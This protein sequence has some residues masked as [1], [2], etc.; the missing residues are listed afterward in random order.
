VFGSD[1][2]RDI[3][4]TLRNDPMADTI[5]KRAL[6]AQDDRRSVQ[7]YRSGPAHH[8]IEEEAI[9]Y[10]VEHIAAKNRGLWTRVKNAVRA[11]IAKM[12]KTMPAKVNLTEDEILDIVKSAAKAWA[13][14]KLPP[15]DSTRK[16][17]RKSNAADRSAQADTAKG[18]PA[19]GAPLSE[20]AQ[21]T[22]TAIH[23]AVNNQWQDRA[24]LRDNLFNQV[25][26]YTHSATSKVRS[27]LTHYINE[28]DA[29][30]SVAAVDQ[31]RNA[32]QYARQSLQEGY[33]ALSAGTK[34]FNGERGQIDPSKARAIGQAYVV[35][36]ERSVGNLVKKLEAVA[37]KHGMSYTAMAN[38]YT[39]LVNAKRAKAYQTDMVGHMDEF[40]R[41]SDN[42]K[43]AE[44]DH[45][46]AA[47]HNRAAQKKILANSDRLAA[48]HA[49][50]QSLA[51]ATGAIAARRRVSI[52]ADVAKLQHENTVLTSGLYDVSAHEKKYRPQIKDIKA[53]LKAATARVQ[54]TGSI[55]SKPFIQAAAEYSKEH[56]HITADEYILKIE[57]ELSAKYPELEDV[58]KLNREILRDQNRL[59]YDAHLIDKDAYERND[60]NEFYTPW[61]RD[62]V[63]EGGDVDG[64]SAKIKAPQKLAGLRDSYGLNKHGSMREIGDAVENTMLQHNRAVSRSLHN[65]AG[66][67]LAR[68]LVAIGDAEKLPQ[69]DI[70]QVPRA[71]RANMVAV[72]VDGKQELYR[73]NDINDVSAFM[74]PNRAHGAVLKWMSA[75]MKVPRML[76]TLDPSF[77]LAQPIQDMMSAGIISG[78]NTP[79]RMMADIMRTIPKGMA[80]A[81]RD[82]M[83]YAST[84]PS[85]VTLSRE[86]GITGRIDHDDGL[87]ESIFT[88]H[89]L[90][91]GGLFA[92]AKRNVV[93]AGRRLER[94]NSVADAT[95]RA[96]IYDDV[97]A[98]KVAEG[99]S[100]VEANLAAMDVANNVINFRKVGANPITSMLVSTIPFFNAQL[101]SLHV[102][103]KVLS[104]KNLASEDRAR[105]YGTLM[106]TAAKLTSI[107]VIYALATAGDDKLADKS[108]VE[109]MNNFF[110][111]LSNG[112]YI[113]VPVRSEFGF[114]WK[115]VPEKLI[116]MMLRDGKADATISETG[117]AIL[118]GFQA[119][120]LPQTVGGGGALLPGAIK[121]LI[122]LGMNKSFYS[123]SPIVPSSLSGLPPS[124][125]WDGA[126]GELATLIGWNAGISPKK[127]DHLLRSYGGGLT[128]WLNTMAY[129]TMTDE[130]A[131]KQLY[132]MPLIKRFM[133]SEE[134]SKA[135]QE[136]YDLIT[137]QQSYVKAAKKAALRGDITGA[138]YWNRKLDDMV[139]KADKLKA[140][141]YQQDA[142]TRA[143]RDTRDSDKYDSAEKRRLLDQLTEQRSALAQ[144]VLNAPE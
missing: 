134:G 51:G 66:V 12:F 75:F 41:L 65:V 89:G 16:F 95:Q 60:A 119:A 93:E 108:D 120:Y 52:A 30:W 114:M 4:T 113:R 143:I 126:T 43:A 39:Q 68:D 132:Q 138:D 58:R 97:Y 139:I 72:T 8:L 98:R 86:G 59:R 48:L 88:K 87:F 6:Y 106:R 99:Q 28:L 130:R 18:K 23:Q 128:V 141:K 55:Y 100:P 31:A 11:Y 142:I 26:D 25:F 94:M 85:I 29:A 104:G 105:A 92:G 69:T 61:L 36:S 57:R 112:Q 107:A 81:L 56:G 5:Y 42:L 15:T 53:E 37:A 35:S 40:D 123:D 22:R 136:L 7:D 80:E 118:K 117:K 49:Q 79:F 54:D 137:E 32:D 70:S 115:F 34:G 111:P 71:E 20:H 14:D 47:T 90:Q 116:H 131:D 17:S 96:R 121:P 63:D 125:Q 109:R 78:T 101:Q 127:L 84:D 110:I 27:K 73:I 1:L 102:V 103:M 77:I 122:E 133:A 82:P 2:V 21:F 83:T 9:G 91:S 44:K 124:E 129:S 33:V 45:N 3:Q 38:I 46:K 140:A 144:D 50:S 62:M 135:K 67:A 10:Y 74:G 76:I 64:I 13:D 19:A 24:K